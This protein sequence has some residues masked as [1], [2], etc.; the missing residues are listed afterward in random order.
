MTADELLTLTRLEYG[1]DRL[2]TKLT[3]TTTTGERP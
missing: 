3:Q 2:L 1:L